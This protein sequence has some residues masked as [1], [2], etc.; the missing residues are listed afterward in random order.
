MLCYSASILNQYWNV[1]N[2]LVPISSLSH[3]HEI[4]Q[5]LHQTRGHMTAPELISS[6]LSALTPKSSAL[7][8]Y[9]L[10]CILPFPVCIFAILR[11]LDL[12]LSALKCFNLFDWVSFI[13]SIALCSWQ[14][15]EQWCK[16]Q[17]CQIQWLFQK[18][19]LELVLFN[20]FLNNSVK[21]W[22]ALWIWPCPRKWIR[23]DY[24]SDFP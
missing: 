22:K 9:L 12:H 16:D 2:I 18:T 4:C 21:N 5:G 8:T 1:L 15:F 24:W 20:E 3:S 10:K 13:I 19:T 17:K 11:C 23:R 6:C 7:S 14:H